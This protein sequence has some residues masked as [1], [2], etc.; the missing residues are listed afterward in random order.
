MIA[1]SRACGVTMARGVKEGSVPR[2]AKAD[3]DG[4]RRIVAPVENVTR[5]TA[6]AGS[7]RLHQLLLRRWS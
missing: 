4:H 6:A 1:G 7:D 5:E 3:Q 2:A